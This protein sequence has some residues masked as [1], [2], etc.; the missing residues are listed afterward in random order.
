VL[1]VQFG[2]VQKLP[3]AGGYYTVLN[4][5]TTR[6]AYNPQ[7]LFRTLRYV[8]SISHFGDLSIEKQLI[9]NN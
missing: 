8:Y 7:L 9:V 1:S 3:T 2:A 6:S 4:I 5:G